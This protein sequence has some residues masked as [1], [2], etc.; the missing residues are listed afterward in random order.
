ME[1]NGVVSD[2]CCL[3]ICEPIDDSSQYAPFPYLC[4]ARSMSPV[5]K[6]QRRRKAS[7]PDYCNHDFV[8]GTSEPSYKSPSHGYMTEASFEAPTYFGA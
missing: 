3:A 7:E 5:V 6:Q 8:H 1:E 2:D 4:T